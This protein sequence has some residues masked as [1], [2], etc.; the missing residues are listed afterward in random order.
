MTKKTPLPP[1]TPKEKAVLEFIE[2]QI[3]SL[4]ISPSYQEIKEYFNLAS[5]NSVQNY[6]KQLTN[7][8]YIENPSGMKRAILVLHSANSVQNQL[9][10]KLV[11]TETGS[12]RSQLLQARDEVLS[13]PLLGKVAAGQPIENIKHDEFIDVPPSMVKNPKKSFALKVQGNS[14]IEEGIFEDDIILVESQNSAGSG[15]IIVATVDNE[16]TV[17]RIYFRSQPGSS[18]QKKMVELRPANSEMSSMWYEP[19]DVAIRGRVV[20]LIRKF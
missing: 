3:L 12:P 13:L 9:A 18:S 15:E 14:M 8:G 20:G 6:L 17:K 2:E 4:G 1:L 7:K 11:S 19:E 10:S 5:F 16:A